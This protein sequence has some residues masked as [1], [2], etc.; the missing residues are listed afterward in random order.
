[1]KKWILTS[2]IVMITG[3][4]SA[5]ATEPDVELIPLPPTDEIQTIEHG[6][7][8]REYQLFIPEG[9]FEGAP[10]VIMMHGYT[11]SHLNLKA[12]SLMDDVARANGFVVAYLLG[13]ETIGGPHWNADLALSD[14]DDIGFVH[15]VIETLTTT[16]NVSEENVFG[17]GFSNGAF[18]TYTIACRAPETFKA[19]APVAGL[20][21]GATYEACEDPEPMNILHIHGTGDTV[22]PIDGSMTLLGGF[23]GGP[24]VNEHFNFWQ[25]AINGSATELSEP[26]PGLTRLESTGDKGHRLIHMYID[27]FPHTWPVSPNPNELGMDPGIHASKEIWDFFSA[28]IT[29]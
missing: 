10:L 23:G 20:M 28:F 8:V 16:Y 19:I 11:S 14:V 26:G 18:M 15:T 1:M 6:D 4:L 17:S 22:V 5:C 21:S 3:V 29:N 12:Q 9:S 25:S 24:N 7:L 13:T 27:D 2:L